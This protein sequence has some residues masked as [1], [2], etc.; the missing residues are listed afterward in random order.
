MSTGLKQPS[1][2]RDRWVRGRHD[3]VRWGDGDERQAEVTDPAA[4]VQGGPVEHTD[5]ERG[6][7]V[8][9]VDELAASRCVAQRAPR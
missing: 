1:S 9:L 8:R 3:R 7:A 6:R 5:H 2:Y 4:T